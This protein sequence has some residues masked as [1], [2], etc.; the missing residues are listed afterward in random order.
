[1]QNWQ[2]LQGT[3]CTLNWFNC[4][5]LVYSK[6]T[7]NRMERCNLQEGE[8]FTFDCSHDCLHESH[9]NAVASLDEQN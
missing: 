9:R 7:F 5:L 4:L 1:M 2:W 6:V 8:D 3:N